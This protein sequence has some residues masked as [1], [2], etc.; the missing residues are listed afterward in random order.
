MLGLNDEEMAAYFQVTQPTFDKWKRDNPDFLLALTRGR[1]EADAKVVESL[2]HRAR[3]YSH[4]AVKIFMPAGAKAPVIVPYTEHYPP[5]T[6]AAS[7]WLHNRQRGKWK[8]RAAETEN[9]GGGKIPVFNAP[10]KVDFPDHDG[11]VLEK[12][13]DG[14]DL[15]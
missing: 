6:A 10:P 15:D 4:P 3:G 1:E 12:T 8:P 14:L 2:Y 13:S 11:P 5:D 7:L 9:A